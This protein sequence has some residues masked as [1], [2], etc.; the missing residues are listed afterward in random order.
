[1]IYLVFVKDMQR[2]MQI[3]QEGSQFGLTT[4]YMKWV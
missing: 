4:N 2:R 3:M 1:M